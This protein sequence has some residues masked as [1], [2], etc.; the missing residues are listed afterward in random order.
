MHRR[1]TDLE[2]VAARDEVEPL[3]FLRGLY[4]RLAHVWA[5][6]KALCV[7]GCAQRTVCEK[8]H[9]YHTDTDYERR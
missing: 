4:V 5:H 7:R 2:L 3:P 6:E 8:R 1:H 9:D